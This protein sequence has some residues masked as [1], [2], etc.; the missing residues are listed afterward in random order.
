MN[1][2]EIQSKTDDDGNLKIHFPLNRRNQPVRVLVLM[3]DD[4]SHED[5][6][7]WLQ[8]IASNPAFEFLADPAEDVYS[9]N[10]GEPIHD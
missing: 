2:I 8:A 5:D 4:I 10:D 6:L 1:A 3:D 7:A 9:I